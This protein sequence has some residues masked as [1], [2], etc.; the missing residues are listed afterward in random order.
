MHAATNDRYDPLGAPFEQVVAAARAGAEWAWAELYHGVAPDLLRYLRARGVLDPDDV[1]GDA[2]VRVV[3]ALDGFSRDGDAFRAWVFT[4][5]RHIAIDAARKRARRPEEPRDDLRGIAPA[6]DAEA[7]ALRA[8]ETDHVRSVLSTLS[9]DQRDVVL[10]RVLSDLSF[11]EIAG[12]MGKREGS[13][14][15]IC[16]RAL[17]ALRAKIFEGRVTL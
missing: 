11:A 15:M 14:R 10:L 17:S 7:D 5:G 6:G 12:V 1:V 9:D 13:V 2:F 4:I 16:A 3:R 8:L